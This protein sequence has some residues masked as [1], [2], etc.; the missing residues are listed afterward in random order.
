MNKLSI[1]KLK[2]LTKEHDT[3][4]HAPFFCVG[5]ENIFSE[6]IS[7]LKSQ[8]S[9]IADLQ[10]SIKALEQQGSYYPAKEEISSIKIGGTD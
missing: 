3:K 6:I 1:E 7:T 4:G 2:K 8:S 10:K 5:V 9:T